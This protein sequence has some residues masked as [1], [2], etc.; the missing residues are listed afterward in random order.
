MAIISFG[1]DFG[2]EKCISS[3]RF[4]YEYVGSNPVAKYFVWILLPVLLIQFATGFVHVLAPQAIGS[5]IPEI[6]TILRGVVLKEYLTGRTL[7]AKI[8]GLTV[9]LGSGMPLGKE[10]PFVHIASI[11]AT[12]MSKLV[13][14]FQGIYSNESRKFE[15]L[16]AAAAVGVSCCFAA[17]VGGVLFSIECTTAFFAVRNYWRGFFAAVCGAIMFR[18]MAIWTN[19]ADT[20]VAVFKTAFK[21]EY[22]FDPIELFVFAGIGAAC[23][24]AG[25]LYV[26][27]HRRYVLWMRANKRLSKFLQ[28]NRFIYPTVIAFMLATATF[29]LGLGQFHA[30]ILGTPDQVDE[31]F[32]NVTWVD[33]S[34]NLPPQ[35]H[36]IRKHWENPFSS[37]FANLAIYVVYTFFGSILASTLPVPTGVVIPSFKTGA[38]F[39]RLIGEAMAFWFPLGI[40]YG[41][42]RHFIVPGGY[43]TAGA[44]AFT[45]AVTHT[46]S[47]S[48]IVFEMT[49]QITHLIPIL[50]S[51]LVS[52]AV[53]HL[54]GPSCFDSIILIKK[55]PYLPD[56]L[57]SRSTAYTVF[58]EDFMLRDVKFIWSRMTF[59]EL[60]KQLVANKHLR[61]FPLVDNPNQMVLLGSIQRAE[62]IHIIQQ[63]ISNHKRIV[64]AR[65]RF[66]I[67]RRQMLI[68]RQKLLEEKRLMEEEEIQREAERLAR[69]DLAMKH[70][71]ERGQ[72]EESDLKEEEE[73]L[74]MLQSQQRR[75]SRFEVTAIESVAEVRRPEDAAS[76][77]LK[78]V[79]EGSASSPKLDDDELALLPDV[80]LLSPRSILKKS[81]AHTIHSLP[82]GTS[83]AT[84]LDD[85][86]D[87]NGMPVYQT[88][89]GVERHPHWKNKLQSLFKR[90]SQLTLLSASKLDTSRAGGSYGQGSSGMIPIP[91][92]M[93]PDEVA[94]WEEEQMQQVVDF[95]RCQIDPAPF[96]LV[97][98]TSLLKVHN[99]FSMCGVNLA[100]VTSIGKL[101]GVVGLTELRE[102]IDSANGVK[103]APVQ[104]QIRI[105][106]CEDAEKGGDESHQLLEKPLTSSDSKIEDQ[107]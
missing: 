104:P 45:G 19:K 15:M 88:V 11:V 23:G 5:G 92:E 7:I 33:T 25:G 21:M 107:K 51:V 69:E 64:A 85:D 78:E 41:D 18:L 4:L 55:L 46:L 72:S 93:P 50:I 37:I 65:K 26:Y 27:T 95:S 17:P 12:L 103:V 43:A 57:P 74:A 49:G 39:G 71:K 90:P 29:P 48:V 105:P 40:S 76:D 44:A 3:R 68:E 14:R 87:E 89:S 86:D 34:P 22:P 54:L 60:K 98:K 47:I 100:Y 8:V 101:I 91:P 53:A 94:K 97:E 16:A 58:V 77:D 106:T 102:G 2:I 99:L 67:H 42:M 62:L 35:H 36:R 6:K 73:A 9:T 81:P 56:I 28:K 31:L 66:E 38:A 30:G 82:R 75:P 32:S 1:I 79:P 59:I 13:T 24:A 83:P 70:A 10:G 63:Q 52:N 20:V 96:Q 84:L 80:S 61:S